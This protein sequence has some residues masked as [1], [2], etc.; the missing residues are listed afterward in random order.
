MSTLSALHRQH[1]LAGTRAEGDAVSTGRSLQRPEHAGLVRIAIAV[2]RV[3]RTLLFDQHPPTREQLHQSGDDFVRHRLQRCVGRRRNFDEF[4]HSVGTAPVHAVQH[5]AVQVNVE[6]GR[7]AEALDQ[8]DRAAVG[9]VRL[10]LSLAEQ[11]LRDYTVHDLQHGR[12]Q[13]GLCGQQQAQRGVIGSDSTHWRTGTCGMTWSTRCAAVCAIRRAPHDGQD[14]RRL[15]LNATS[16]SWPQSPQRSRRKPCARMPH[17]RNASNSSLMNCG[18]SAPA[19][20]SAWAKKVA[21]CCCTRRYSVVWLAWLAALPT[22]AS[23]SGRLVMAS[24]RPPGCAARQY[25]LHQL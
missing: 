17:S 20:S 6:V 14:P 5:Q 4:R 1:L 23:S 3:G 15:Q 12:H 11:V 16:L 25:Q 2:G 21:A 8:R 9:F 10:E 22:A 13:L 19:A 24:S 18:R 7:R